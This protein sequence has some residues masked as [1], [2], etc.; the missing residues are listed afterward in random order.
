[1]EIDYSIF[2]KIFEQ[3]KR[4]ADVLEGKQVSKQPAPE[5]MKAYENNNKSIEKAT[6]EDDHEAFIE[7]QKKSGWEGFKKDFIRELCSGQAL[8]YLIMGEYSSVK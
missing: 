3:L 6:Q 1:M 7:Q 4:I 8:R 2:F 5:A